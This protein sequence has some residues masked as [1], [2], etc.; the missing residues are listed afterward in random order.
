MTD[1]PITLYAV[2]HSLYSARARSYLFKAGIAFRERATRGGH[3]ENVIK[4]KAGG[5]IT[6]PIIE[7][8]NGDVIRDGVAII[9]HFEAQNERA[10]SPKSPKQNVISLLFDVIGAEGLL[11]PAMHYRWSFREQQNEF[12]RFHFRMHSPRDERMDDAIDKDMHLMG[13]VAGPSFGVSPETADLI[14]SLYNDQ[15]QALDRHFA[16]YGY[17][18]GGRP[19]IGDFGM[20][21]PLYAHL[22]RD[23]IP[24]VIML[25]RAKHVFRWVERMNRPDADL[26]EFDNQEED[27]LPGDEIPETLIDVMRAMSEDFVPE[28][29]A[30]A[31]FINKWLAEHNPE[32][33]KRAKRGVGK[34]KFLIRGT[35]IEALAQPYRF[36]QLNRFQAA[37]D[38]LEGDDKTEMDAIL[39]AANMTPVI[40]ARLTRKVGRK[41]NLEIWA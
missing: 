33:G 17:L 4:S 29:V 1:Q 2:P 32:P 18:L 31:N 26:V 27:W 23:P 5:H 16:A 39:E 37:Y 25:D 40:D 22:A 13:Q 30:A 36:Y 11:R 41:G 38:A 28:T 21:G 8:T 6:I 34:A 24:K 10:F 9:D 3:V 20:I 19:C 14:E 35:E 7:F 12:L 15:L